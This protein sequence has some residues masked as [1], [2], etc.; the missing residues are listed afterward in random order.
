MQEQRGRVCT[1]YHI[2]SLFTNGA[3]LMVTCQVR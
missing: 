1:F 3:S 2:K